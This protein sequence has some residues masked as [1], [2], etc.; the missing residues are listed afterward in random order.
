MD[1]ICIYTSKIRIFQKDV[2]LLET[3]V[4]EDFIDFYL[5]NTSIFT[6]PTCAKRRIIY[7]YLNIN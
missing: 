3:V 4:Y 5:Y 6:S 2:T 7:A 1:G